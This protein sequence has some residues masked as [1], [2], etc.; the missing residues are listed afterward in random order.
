MDIVFTVPAQ[1][2]VSILPRTAQ[3]ASEPISPFAKPVQPGLL[4]TLTIMV[5]LAAVCLSCVQANA[6]H[7]SQIVSPAPDRTRLAML[8]SDHSLGYTVHM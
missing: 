6:E 4:N 3:T 7:A 8:L 1:C 5:C 2:P